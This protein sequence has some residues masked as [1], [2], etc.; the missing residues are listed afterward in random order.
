MMTSNLE[1]RSF[2]WTPTLVL[3]AALM[4]GLAGCALFPD[5]D[6][7]GTRLGGDSTAQDMRRNPEAATEPPAKKEPFWEKYRDKR[8]RDV[9]QKLGAVESAGW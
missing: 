5:G 2:R 1:K 7:T 6:T 4:Q 9:D 3:L 8:A